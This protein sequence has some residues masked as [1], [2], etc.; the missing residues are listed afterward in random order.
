MKREAVVMRFRIGANAPTDHPKF[1]EGSD[2]ASEFLAASELP[3]KNGASATNAGKRHGRLMRAAE[4]LRQLEL[5]IDAQPQLSI[6]LSDVAFLFNVER[7]YCSKLFHKIAGKSFSGWV[8]TTRIAKAQ[9]L[10]RSSQ[11]SIT[12][13]SH[14]VGYQ[15]IT[16]FERNFRKE[17]GKNPLAYRQSCTEEM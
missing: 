11:L 6:S 12:D 1:R 2:L 5:L 7:T 14:A 3:M 8:R 4:K 15:D 9:R 16:T 10:L 17:L 13:V